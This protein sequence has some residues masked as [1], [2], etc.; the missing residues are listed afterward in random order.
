MKI[1]RTYRYRFYPDAVEA[2]QVARTF[3]CRRF[4]FNWALDRRQKCYAAGEPSNYNKDSAAL[5]SL[6]KDP[7]RKWLKEVSSVALQQALK[8]LDDAYQNFF[9]KK[10]AFP[11]FKRKEGWQSFR[12]MKNAFT[13][14]PGKLQLA[15]MGKPLNVV[16]TRPFKGVPSQVTV[17]RDSAGR[18]FVSLLVEEDVKSFV[19]NGKCEGIDL[20]LSTFATFSS[21]RPSVAPSR[22][23]K[24][25]LERV[26]RLSRALSRKHKASKNRAKARKRLARLHARIADCRNDF[27]HKLST[28]LVR[29]NQALFVESLKVVNL[30]KNSRLARAIGDAAWG[31]FLRQLEYKCEWYGR[32]LWQ[33]PSNFP[34]SKRCSACGFKLKVLPLSVRKWTCPECGVMH[35]RDKNAASNLLNEGLLVFSTAGH[36]GI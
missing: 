18:Y 6:K 17:S 30:M 35:D 21:A 34:S 15:K 2:V 27:L 25:L 8:D 16:W 10:S 28:T 14:S 11:R 1:L 19:A 24:T 22:F 29:E 7:E 31:E 3:G 13:Y 9:S 33:A 36:A 20:G 5:T 26:R 23:L 12:L 32:Y 4:I